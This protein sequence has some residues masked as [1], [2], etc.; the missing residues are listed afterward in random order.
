[1]PSIPVG[2]Q[3]EG[4]HAPSATGTA[5][6]RRRHTLIAWAFCSPFLLLFAGFYVW[7]LLASFLLGFTNMTSRNL[8]AP[9]NA[10]VVG[11]GNYAELLVDPR[12]M[13]ALI[14]T[15]YFVGV[16]VPMTMGVALAIAVA[17]NSPLL[18]FKSLLRAA[19]F[20]PVV[21]SIVAVAVVWRYLY[22][23]DGLINSALALIGVSG[24]NWL[25][26]PMWAMPAMILMAVWRNLGIPMVIFLAGLQGIPKDLY[27]AASVDGA[28][29]WRCLHSITLP[30][31]RPSML[32]VTVLL[33]IGFLQFFEEPFVMTNGGPLDSTT[34]ISYY[35][36]DQFGYGQYGLASAAA[37]VLVAFIG[38][39]SA[40]Q[41][42]LFRSRAT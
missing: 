10:D 15:L 28:S 12:F 17:L 2:R 14:N 18:R 35:V 36:Y 11:L 33:S 19:Y 16:G 13:R 34:S 32:V 38:L 25:N 22:R 21:T 1:M 40:V 23:D 24:P 20:L 6:L 30:L 31:L 3:A 4:A 42:W 37:Y 8:R 9:L 39:F 5:R 7:P 27:E 26:D 29:K 41:F